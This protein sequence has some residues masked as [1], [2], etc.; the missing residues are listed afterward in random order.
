MFPNDQSPRG[1]FY[2][3]AKKAGKN[4]EFHDAMSRPKR[5]LSDDEAELFR[6]SVGGIAPI[7]RDT[8]DPPVERP[9]PKARFRAKDE[10]AVLDE[11][12]NGSIDESEMNA[13]DYLRFQRS[14]VS[15]RTFRRLARG[16][17]SIQAE[18]DLHGLTAAQAREVLSE[19]LEDSARRGLRCVR[20]IHGKGMR[21]GERGPVLKRR[22]DSWLRQW[23]SVL[24]FSSA[25]QVDG[26]TGA[27][28]VLLRGR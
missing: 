14:S 22:I 20:I 2:V 11:S 1:E 18:S 5:G 12:L 4:S 8:V 6:A 13:G 24:A 10:R 25:R 7:R 27:V 3:M 17:F 19:F 28:Y 9:S 16:A 21:S 23:D 15:A 26:G